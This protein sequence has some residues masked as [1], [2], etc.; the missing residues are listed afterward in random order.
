MRSKSSRRRHC[1]PPIEMNIAMILEMAADAYGDRVAVTDGQTSLSYVELRQ[2]ALAAAEIIKGNGSRNTALLDVNSTAVPVAL[3]GSALAGAPYAPVNYRLTKDELS[4][5][6]DRIAPATLFT[7]TDAFSGLTA[8]KG[9]I[10]SDR[11]R[12]LAENS[13]ERAWPDLRGD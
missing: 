5:L 9:M 7:T 6:L 4:D 8:P 10:L 13:S 3:F 12:L 1:L 11:N 2:C